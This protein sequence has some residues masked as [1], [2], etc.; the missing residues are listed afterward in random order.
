LSAPPVDVVVLGGGAAGLWCA[1]A[2]GRRGRR[3]MVLEHNE[4][5]GKKILI[6]GGGRAN[7]TNRRV[8]AEHFVSAN[9]HFARS[10]LAR[11]PPESVI[12]L[13]EQHRIPYHERKHGQLFCDDSAKRITAMLLAECEAVG[14]EIRT[15]CRVDSVRALEADAPG[16]S[17]RVRYAVDTAT[18]E[19]VCRSLVVATGGLSY[20]QLGASDLGYRIARQFGLAIVAP[21]PGLVPLQWSRAERPRWAELA[22]VAVPARV[23]CG[24][25]S[26]EEATLFTHAGLSG[27]AILQI[28]NHWRL[29]QPVR[30]DWL[31]HEDL[32]DDLRARKAAGDRTRLLNALSE[33]LPK[34]LAERL[35]HAPTAARPLSQCADADLD[36]T[37]AAVH[38][39]SFRPAEDAGWTKA[40]V[41]LGGVDTAGLSS[42]TLE[43]RTAPGLHFIGEVVDVTGWLG[44]FNFQWAWASAQAAGEAV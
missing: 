30:I 15:G 16:G 43:A 36:A 14:V 3:V 7:F 27:P 38:G 13:V 33:R 31:P 41:T 22:G 1:A 32:R 26:F 5:V 25:A 24:S 40:E 8:G 23:T 19:V 35:V 4:R 17:G 11:C 34:R 28:S 6:S 12:A 18:D 21:R 37:A 39:F 20:A 2:A 42:R 9:P 10:A 29:G 44:G